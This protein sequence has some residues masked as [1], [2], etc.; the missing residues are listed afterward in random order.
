MVTPELPGKPAKAGDQGQKANGQLR[1]RW[2]LSVIVHRRPR[3][4]MELAK[5]NQRRVEFI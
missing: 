2:M 5:G 4:S 3:L 1:L